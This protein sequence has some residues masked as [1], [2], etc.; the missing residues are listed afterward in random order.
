LSS[1]LIFN[2]KRAWGRGSKNALFL[3]NIKV[4][5]IFSLMEENI[6]PY[7]PLSEPDAYT[8]LTRWRTAKGWSFSKRGTL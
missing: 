5:T 6:P 4:F 7:P 3:L 1:F 8:L 2:K